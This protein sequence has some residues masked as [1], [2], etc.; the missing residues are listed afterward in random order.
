MLTYPLLFTPF[1]RC[2]LLELKIIMIIPSLEFQVERQ[3]L[4]A[5]FHSL[6]HL[7]FVISKLVKE[8]IAQQP[9]VPQPAKPSEGGFLRQPFSNVPIAP[10]EHA[11][12]IIS[13]EKFSTLLSATL[14]PL[15]S[16]CLIKGEE[17]INT[18]QCQVHM[19]GC[20]IL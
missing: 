1:C 14:W 17:L 5:D 10:P 20:N 12:D 11:V 7:F 18:K 16:T 2:F 3:S 8:D 4:L 13:W 6:H 15:I 19:Y 9:S